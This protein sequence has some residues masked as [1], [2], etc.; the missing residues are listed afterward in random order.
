M[1]F[2]GRAGRPG[3]PKNHRSNP[4]DAPPVIETIGA[5]FWGGKPTQN[6]PPNRPPR[7]SFQPSFPPRL[8]PI[9]LITALFRPIKKP[10]C[11]GRNFDTT[12]DTAM[13]NLYKSPYFLAKSG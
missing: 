6:H 11:L 9:F 4:L 13:V 12:L 7:G 2:L 3:T 10:A 5:G 1:K 8:G